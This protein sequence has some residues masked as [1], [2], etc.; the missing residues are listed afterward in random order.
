MSLLL[1]FSR[2][3]WL[4]AA[5]AIAAY[6]L[7]LPRPE[8]GKG[9]WIM[10]AACCCALV[11]AVVALWQFD[12]VRDLFFARLAFQ[13]YDADRFANQAIAFQSFFEAPIGIGPGQSEIE[14]NY[15]THNLFARLM[16]ENGLLGFLA[17]CA[18]LAGAFW[19]AIRAVAGRT[20]TR[21]AAVVF[22]VLLGIAAN[23]LF[24]DS[25]HWRHFWIFLGFAYGL[26]LVRRARIHRAGSLAATH[27]AASA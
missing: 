3:A 26:P 14:L 22:A 20:A 4:N 5:V 23:S 1:S 7:L 16:F 15:A 25:L 27:K 8:R 2:A 6:V 12:D 18:L 13:E 21:M 10:A 9:L 17:I 11:C 24:I 19:R